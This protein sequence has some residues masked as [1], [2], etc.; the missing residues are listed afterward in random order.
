MKLSHRSE[1]PYYN[2]YITPTIDDG[3]CGGLGNMMWRFASMYAI[4]KKLGRSPYYDASLSC[5]KS[6]KKEV[7]EMLPEYATRIQ[8]FTPKPD[9]EKTINFG[10]HCC[11]Y[12]ST[13]ML[14]NVTEKYVHL[15]GKYF[16]SLAFFRDAQDEIRAFFNWSEAARRNMSIY[17]AKLFGA[18]NSH[19]LC[20]HTRVGD[21]VGFKI[22]T[23]L[24]FTE[25]ALEYSF[26]KVQE[27][28]TNVSVVLLGEDKKF[29][30]TIKFDRRLITRVYQPTQMSRLEDMCFASIYCDSLLITASSSTFAWWIGYLMD[31][32]RNSTVGSVF[33]NS[34]F[35]ATDNYNFDNFPSNWTPLKLIPSI[36]EDDRQYPPY[37]Q[38]QYY[39]NQ[40]HVIY[41]ERPRRKSNN[42]LAALFAFCCGC[43]LGQACCDDGDVCICCFPCIPIPLPIRR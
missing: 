34:D 10:D 27:K 14:Q 11:R 13:N 29:L 25:M 18:D 24:N 38:G 32:T 20:V 28:Y 39:S 21:F 31:A 30:Q 17:A 6:A 2:R 4:G 5:M 23:K 12:Q 16:Q 35:K 41:E 42:W 3:W 43:C 8:F 1:H 19:K 33:Y 15:S 22:Q 7:E 9:E 37:P 40:P 26:S 36:I